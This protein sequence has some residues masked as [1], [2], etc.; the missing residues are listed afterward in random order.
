MCGRTPGSEA[1]DDPSVLALS[2]L[3]ADSTDWKL[4]GLRLPH[5]EETVGGI[6]RR[7]RWSP[8]SPAAVEVDGPRDNALAYI[9][10][11]VEFTGMSDMEEDAE[12]GLC[13]AQVAVVRRRGGGSNLG[14]APLF[15]PCNLC[16]CRPRVRRLLVCA[17]WQTYVPVSTMRENAVVSFL[18]ST[19]VG[20]ATIEN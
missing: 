17:P 5:E 4:R 12:R 10:L 1:F 8:S 16:H 19:A 15:K 9:G 13:A 6:D 11:L 14:L 2:K 18:S 20:C 3:V 7:A